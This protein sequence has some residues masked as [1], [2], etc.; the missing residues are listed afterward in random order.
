MTKEQLS[1]HAKTSWKSYFEHESTSLQLPAAELAH[2]SAA[3]TELANALGKSVEGLFFLFFPKSMWLS[4]ATES[5]R[6][7]LQCGTQAADEM[8]ACQRRIKSRRPEYKMKTLQQVQKE[9]QA[10][11]PMQAH[12][13]TTFSGLLCARTLCPLR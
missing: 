13:L 12:E 11:K 6:Y 8:M 10:F 9:L 7:Q 5:N 4:I 1:E 3:P 2:A